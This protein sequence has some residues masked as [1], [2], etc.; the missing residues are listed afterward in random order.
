MV[1]AW[2]WYCIIVFCSLFSLG[3]VLRAENFSHDT[4]LL[5]RTACPYLLSPFIVVK[6]FC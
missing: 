6:V 4:K 3:Y 2:N 1:F 5:S